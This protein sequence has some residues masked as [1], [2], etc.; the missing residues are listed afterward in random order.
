MEK[1]KKQ[2]TKDNVN[3]K[4]HTAS[5]VKQNFVSSGKTT[6]VILLLYSLCCERERSFL[7]CLH[8]DRKIESWP[9]ASRKPLTF[10]DHPLFLLFG[11]FI[12]QELVHKNTRIYDSVHS[13]F[14]LKFLCNIAFFSVLRD[15]S[16]RYWIAFG[17][18]LFQPFLTEK[19]TCFSITDKILHSLYKINEN[20]RVLHGIFVLNTE[21]K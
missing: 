7:P 15:C 21:Q 3:R 5:F 19:T 1:T 6:E 9:N 16:V 13:E 14:H 17:K 12:A 10:V 4:W 11:R 8:S 18:C 20:H 2:E